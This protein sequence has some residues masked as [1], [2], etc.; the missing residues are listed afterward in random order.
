ML[1]T[2]KTLSPRAVDVKR[3]FPIHIG[4]TCNTLTQPLSRS[5]PSRQSCCRREE[6]ACMHLPRGMGADLVGRFEGQGVDINVED[7][8]RGRT[9]IFLR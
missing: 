6:D 3:P 4:D 8:S 9:A 7:Y 5:L 2:V 1:K